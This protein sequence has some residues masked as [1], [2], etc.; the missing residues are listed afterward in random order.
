[1][2]LGHPERA[3]TRGG[4]TPVRVL[5]A[6]L[7]LAPVL[8]LGLAG[9]AGATLPQLEL[10]AACAAFAALMAGGLL[11]AGPRRHAMP[12]L[13]AVMV[14]YVVLLC[15]V[16]GTLG[17]V[18][19]GPP[20]FSYLAWAIPVAFVVLPPGRALL[21][22]GWAVF[23]AIVMTWLAGDV[24]S[25]EDAGRV[26]LIVTTLVVMFT[27]TAVLV[28]RLRRNTERQWM[29]AEFGRRAL[30]HADELALVADVEA[31]ARRLIGREVTV[32]INSYGERES[33]PGVTVPVPLAAGGFLQLHAA[34][35]ASWQ[36]VDDDALHLAGLGAIAVPALERIASLESASHAALHDALTGLPNR[37]LALDRLEHALTRRDAAVAVL[38]LDLDDFK[39]VNDSY[40]HV[41]GD[42][43]LSQLTGRLLTT[44]RPGDTVARLG[45]DE[46][47]VVADEVDDP[48]AAFGLAERL[49][50]AWSRPLAVNGVEHYVSGSVGLALS[51]AASTP[52]DL[53]READ[54][55]MYR[56]KRTGRGRVELYD[57]RMREEV[58][59]E[60]AFESDLHRAVEDHQ[61]RLVF[62]PILDLR[63]GEPVSLEALARW[64]HPVRG[65]VPPDQF[66]PV[67][68]RI[69]LIRDVGEW[70]MRESARVLAQLQ[71]SRGGE[72]VGRLGVT[73]NV[74]PVQI[75]D[76][77]FVSLVQ[78]VVSDSGLPPG[79]LGLEVTEG[80]LLADIEAAAKVLDAVREAGVRVL[81]DDFGT[82][83][84]SLSYLHRFQLD[85]I[86][87]DR[88][89]VAR[90]G[91]DRAARAIVGAVVRIGDELGL[92]VIAEGV[93]N[94]EQF[95]QLRQLSVG[96]A[97]GF[98]LG[99][100][101]PADD[102]GAWLDRD[103]ADA[104]SWTGRIA[105]KGMPGT[106]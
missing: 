47:L 82:G 17:S 88:S 90:L 40:G 54:A 76:P 41:A 64:T 46:F 67:A 22:S 11:T 77:R 1:M 48:V 74:S 94:E 80:L 19:N 24:T 2:T 79:W 43:L 63:T 39:A 6:V 4:A 89:F 72:A 58:S 57:E 13:M 30:G 103:R 35:A 69:G 56:A 97:Q 95:D 86:K 34:P 18:L 100:P 25:W 70:T 27:V 52:T 26:G 87:I 73:V 98:G 106:D 68:E 38:L 55:A 93:E 84:S 91:V 29:L 10:L 12:A 102:A 49:A 44:V 92:E 23:C 32:S 28:L 104:S 14:I 37:V 16:A 20:F 62:Q 66:I 31:T 60:L 101:M 65:A 105:V 45:G 71:K 99:R 42:E 15:V 33:G 61:L 7:I 21:I 9:L 59:N 51:H 8:A 96:H 83:Y 75:E 78:E 53:L 85:A 50:E 5:C 36:D 3:L 81:L